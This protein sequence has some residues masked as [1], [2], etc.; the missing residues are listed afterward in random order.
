MVGPRTCCTTRS[1]NQTRNTLLPLMTGRKQSRT[2]TLR[3]WG[4]SSGSVRQMQWK[5]SRHF[6]RVRVRRLTCEAF[7][8]ASGNRTAKG[9][10]AIN[11]PCTSIPFQPPPILGIGHPS[12]SALFEKQLGYVRFEF[13]SLG[14]WSLRRAGRFWR[15][16]MGRATGSSIR[17]AVKSLEVSRPVS[18]RA[19]SGQFFRIHSCDT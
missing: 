10:R 1:A 15:E 11:A 8:F 16:R 14:A 17:E 18:C 9:S 7:R 13:E 4:A 2:Q 5:S 12:L 19:P 6:L 3:R